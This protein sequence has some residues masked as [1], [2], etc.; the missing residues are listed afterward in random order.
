MSVKIDL[1]KADK[2]VP[3]VQGIHIVG[4]DITTGAFFMQIRAKEGDTGTPLIE[5]A[6]VASGAEG[7]AVSY[8]ATFNYTNGAG[9]PIT[10]T[11]TTLTV[12]INEATLEALAFAN[13]AEVPLTLAYDI[14]IT[15]VGQDKRVFSYGAF[16]IKA[17][18]TI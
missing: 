18:V 10:T 17:G 13:P 14:H 11:A 12:R 9:L 8:D 16:V 7:I 4:P 5:L 15:P 1:P 6:K 3:Y 2:R